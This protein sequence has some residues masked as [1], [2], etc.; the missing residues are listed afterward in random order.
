MHAISASVSLPA[1]PHRH[2]DAVGLEEAD[3]HERADAGGLLVGRHEVLAGD[4]REVHAHLLVLEQAAQKIVRA[5]LHEAP[6][7]AAF[8]A[9]VHH[10]VGR[11]ER[12]GRRVQRRRDHRQP[13][14]RLLREPAEGVRVLL[15]E[16]RDLRAGALADR[17]T[18]RASCRPRT[19]TSSAARGR[20]IRGRSLALSFSSS[21]FSSGLRLDEDVAIECWSCRKPGTVSSRVTTPPPNQA[22]RSSTSTLLAGG[23]EVGGG[24]EAVVAGADGDDVGLLHRC[25]PPSGRQPAPLSGRYAGSCIRINREMR[26]PLTRSMRSAT[27]TWIAPRATISSTAIRTTARCRSTT[28]SGPSSDARGARWIVDTG[29]DAPMARAARPA[30]RAAGGDRASRHR[31]RP[32]AVTRRDRQPHALRPRRQ[33]RRCSRAR[34]ITCRTRRWR[35]APGRAMCHA[36]LRAAVRGAATCR[37][38][39]AKR[40]R[41][42]RGVPRSG[43]RSSRRASRCITSAGTPRGLQVVRVRTQRGWVVLASDAAHF[44]ANWQQRRPFPIVENVT[45][46][47][48]AFRR[49]EAL[50]DSPRHVI[51]GHDPLVLRRYPRALP[52]AADI[53]RLDLDPLGDQD[54]GTTTSRGAEARGPDRVH[55]CGPHGR[56]DGCAP[57]RCRPCASPCSIP[58]PRRS[59]ALAA[60][61]ARA[62]ASAA[63]AARGA[64]VVMASLPT[65]AIVRALAAATAAS[66]RRRR[67][68]W[69]SPPRARRPPRP[70][71]QCSRRAASPRSMR[72]CPAA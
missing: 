40:V 10:R 2:A 23:R 70:S 12:R 49:I 66:R 60:R 5:H 32:A 4:A 39:S 62:A 24:D 50:A 17:D 14:G 19:P 29:F 54:T 71:P 1:P 38:W 67:S 63:E 45:A 68:S 37:R 42:P 65:P 33:S 43:R 9:L 15:R 18:A 47:L 22:L 3:E 44:Y 7:L 25:A 35:S 52:D 21:F 56:P 51:P 6:Q 41:R 16:L 30:A 13:R 58:A 8:A 28:T 27:R 36:P 11:A 69:T 26:Q 64:E 61:G 53:V 57:A 20:C 34:A 48:E 55:W 72:R 31:H 59:H 46:Y